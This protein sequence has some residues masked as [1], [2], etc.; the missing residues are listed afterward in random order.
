VMMSSLQKMPLTVSD[1]EL[2]FYVAEHK[3]RRRASLLRTVFLSALALTVLILILGYATS[4]SLEWEVPPSRDESALSPE[5]GREALL[6]SDRFIEFMERFDREYENNEE[7]MQRFKIYARNMLE[8]EKQNREGKQLSVHGENHL[9]D[10]TDDEFKK[11]LLPLNFYKKLREQNTFIKKNP[12][13]GAKKGEKG[14]APLPDF[15]DWRKKGNYVTPV[16]DQNGCGSCWAFATT[17]TVETQ[18]AIAHGE[19]R[20]L[21]EQTLLDCDLDDN[22]CDGGDVDKAMRFVHRYGLAYRRDYPY[23]A[24]RENCT[25]AQYNR[26][27]IDVAYFIHP[28][29]DSMLDWLVHFGPV[30]IGISV[31]ADM[32]SYKDGVYA[33][34]KEACRPEKII[35]LHALLVVGYGKEEDGTKWWM[36]KNSWKPSW[37]IDGYVKFVRGVNACGIEDEPVGILV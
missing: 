20:D 7:T 8:T 1:A 24:H 23:V 15:F 33:P 31:P 13:K 3:A 14:E 22:A 17:A 4:S 32:K 11:L 19:L 5:Y 26:T 10:W 30:N 21:S 2:D 28:D 6:Y 18:Y 27:T 34:T 36:V 25:A 9:A 37:G 29:E 12:P 16:K 35:G